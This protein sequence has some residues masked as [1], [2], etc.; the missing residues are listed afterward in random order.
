[1]TVAAGLTLFAC[2]S[3]LR[4]YIQPSVGDAPILAASLTFAA[5]LVPGAVSGVL[6]PRAHLVHGALVG[7]GA[8]AFMVMQM[9]NFARLDW[10]NAVLYRTFAALGLLGACLCA[11]GSLAGHALVS[12]KLSSNNLLDRTREN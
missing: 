5:F 4:K 2:S 8:A 10:S 12:C 3:L 6:A 11:I 9:N 1:M 7:L